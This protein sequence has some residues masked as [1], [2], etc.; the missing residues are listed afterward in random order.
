M[1]QRWPRQL[2]RQLLVLPRRRLQLQVVRLQPAL[3]PANA[4]KRSASHS[5][6]FGRLSSRVSSSDGERDGESSL[7]YGESSLDYGESSADGAA[8]G[9][10]GNESAG[11]SLFV[12]CHDLSDALRQA[13]RE[14][15]QK[16][17]RVLN[18]TAK[19]VMANT[20]QCC[21]MVI[22]QLEPLRTS[23]AGTRSE[24]DA[25]VID[26][27]VGLL[28][29]T[30]SE[31]MTGYHMC[32]TAIL[33]A[34]IE[35]GE[36]TPVLETFRLSTL[37]DDLGFSTHKQITLVDNVALDVRGDLQL[38]SCILFN[39]VHNALMHGAVHANVTIETRLE[40]ARLKCAGG[41]SD[42]A[43][44]AAAAAAAGEAAE[45]AKKDST[46][47]RPLRENGGDEVGDE[48]G[49][50]V[51]GEVG[52]DGGG[53]GG[54]DR[55]GDGGG[56]GGGDRDY[57]HVIVRNLAGG[58]HT[59][60]RSMCV[61]DLLAAAPSLAT[62]L[63]Q[64]GVGAEGSTFL[65]LPEIYRASRMVVPHADVHL[66]VREEEVVFELTMTLAREAQASGHI[67]SGQ[68]VFG[69]ASSGQTPSGQAQASQQEA[70]PQALP[71]TSP[72]AG[73]AEATIPQPLPP[74]EPSR[75]VLPNAT[76][77][78][79]ALPPG[80]VFVC[81]DDD[82]IPRIFA[83]SVL[84]PAARADIHASQ[85]IGETYEEVLHVPDLVMELAERHGHD[86]V[87]GLFDQ[88]LT[89]YHEG[90]VFGTGLCRELRQRGF[91]G[92]LV[93]QSANDEICAERE[94]LA[95]GANGSL[96][97]VLRGGPEEL[98]RRLAALWAKGEYTLP[99]VSPTFT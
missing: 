73:Q 92:C 32:R 14:I 11:V 67:P 7:D 98:I 58:N 5:G 85:V 96:G 28:S 1:P 38:L 33:Q 63:R 2:P 16:A 35:S 6:S 90:A 29:T 3:Q 75:R 97:K 34:G 53:D 25:S 81:C 70:L 48:V 22:A 15:E 56:D 30:L 89:N 66:W 9:G 79:P 74:S 51:R 12:V 52:G 72:H 77:A 80:M 17:H 40:R 59:A 42:A 20:S 23:E 87:C 99:I 47:R 46:G 76:V 60:L 24:D 36:H 44:V 95:A 27:A 21:R 82:D 10:G 62:A 31:S 39:A 64:Q 57:L 41:Q 18:H 65:G 37:F 86:R 4:L 49:G 54:G 13:E 50:K 83:E 68:A 55:G 88:N 43:E 69:Q 26:S 45:A 19:R 91:C 61:S 93:I 8:G 94:Y 84:L 78:D 71:Q